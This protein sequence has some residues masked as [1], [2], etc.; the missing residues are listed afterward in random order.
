[1]NL[2]LGLSPCPN[3]T[4][5]FDAMLNGK[6]DT[7]G[8]TFTYQLEDVETLNRLAKSGSL[9]ISKISYGALPPLLPQYCVLNA[10]GALGR[11][12]G[13][14]FIS[15]KFDGK[16][17]PDLSSLSVALPGIQT[18]AHLLFSMSYPEVKNKSF[19]PFHE[20][21]EAV[22]QDKVDAGVIIHENRFTYQEK[23][24]N[25]L[26]DLGEVWEKNTGHPIPLG[27]IV[28]RRNYDLSLLQKINR[29]IYNSLAYAFT[30]HKVLPDFVTTNAQEMSEEIMRNHIDLYVND[31]SLNLGTAGR[32][33]VWKLLELSN[34]INN[35]TGGDDLEVFID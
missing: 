24:L 33:A 20:I 19:L 15:K 2:T 7:E 3:D 9:D 4:F 5:I 1:M 11:G 26:A 27:G 8:L 14:I 32:S 22:L 28:A 29:I 12:V 21:E 35:Y 17:N 6:I 30:H 31:F 18:T 16:S 25:K 10:G 23:G 13:P 34:Q